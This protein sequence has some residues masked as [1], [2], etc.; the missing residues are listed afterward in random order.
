MFRWLPENVSS[1]GADI[2]GIMKMIWAIVFAWFVLT[3][4][5]LFYFLFRYR[6]RPGG[7]AAFESGD[8][9]KALAWILVP[10]L[11]VLGFDLSIE[12]FQNPVWDRVKIH[13]PD[14]P[15]QTIRVQGQQFVWNFTLPGRD[16]ALDTADDIKTFNQL[17]V[18]VHAKIEFLLGSEDVL[19]SFWLPNL[20][21]KQDAVPGRVIKGWF[22]ATKEGTYPIAC[23][24]LCGSGHGVMKGELRVLNKK[25]FEKW[26]EEN[27]PPIQGASL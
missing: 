12:V 16:G 2:D 14:H 21:L 22:E 25:D 19:H 20:R 5:V 6:R 26:L 24:E 9:W 7:K 11:L 3:E 1:Y 18:P 10:A 17:V 27:S 15:D 23:A 8:T 4:A 13:L